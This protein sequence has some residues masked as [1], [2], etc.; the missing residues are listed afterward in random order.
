MLKKLVE[1]ACEATGAKYGALGVI[2]EHKTLVEFV[3]HGIDPDTVRLIG[4]VPEGRG[5]LGTLIKERASIRLDD[6]TTHPDSV[7]FPPHHPPM[8]SFLGVAVG[9]AARA[10]GNLYLAEKTGGFD[11]DD[12]LIVE[13][14]AAIAAA[15]VETTRLRTRLAAIAVTEDRQ[16][17]GRDLHD[18]II[19]DLFGTGLQLQGLAAGTTDETVRVGLDDAVARIDETIDSL[20]SI[21]SDLS[22]R[23]EQGSFLEVLHAQVG[24]LAGPYQVNP[25]ITVEPPTLRLSPEMTDSVEPIVAEAVS[26]ALRHSD[27]DSIELRV[28]LLGDRLVISVVDQGSGFDTDGVARGMGLT[29]LK[30]RASRLGGM[31][32]IRS[33]RGVGTSVEVVLPYSD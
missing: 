1:I 21:V 19:Q 22:K 31:A 26:N 10:F 11:E 20:R 14:L 8:G 13:A 16:R 5:V 32:A 24:R 29:N 15:A 4:H 28:D 7:G 23:R 12:Q 27:S 30:K 3:H 2:G 9:S 25:I 6:L 33:V 17:I 18:S